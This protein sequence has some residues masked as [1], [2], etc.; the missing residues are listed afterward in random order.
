LHLVI[1]G[2]PGT[3]KG[4]QAKLLMERFGWP[5][6]SSGDMLREAVASKSELG[7]S[8]KSYM[9][10]GALVPD[11]LVIK[12]LI[13]RIQRP[14][15]TNGFILDGFPRTLAQA[16]ALDEELALNGRSIDAS[17]HFSVPRRE[18]VRRLS[19]R[20]SCP[21][22][23][24]IY[25]LLDRPPKQEGVCDRC[26]ATLVQR[27]DDRPQTVEARLDSQWPPEDLLAHYRRQG[28]LVEIDG[29]RPVASVTDS[30]VES[31][32]SRASKKQARR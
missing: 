8:A 26:G 1:L 16:R 28:K 6:I 14:D 21:N 29:L 23:G 9:D 19:S 15:A 27:E 32:K 10:Q 2:A 12:M 7:R 3:G 30:L 20:W 17:L 25:N 5:H 31:V 24:A 22:C 4:T 13:E 11:E 18:L